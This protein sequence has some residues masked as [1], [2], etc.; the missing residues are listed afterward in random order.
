MEYYG[1]VTNGVVV[2]E[3]G[4][5]LPEG[6]RVRVSPL[7]ESSSIGTSKGAL[8]QRLLKYAGKAENL[9]A[10]MA[11]QHDHYLHGRPKR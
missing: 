10:D 9:P 11:D 6:M 7:E 4:D 1:K 3:K 5:G 2:L 8:G